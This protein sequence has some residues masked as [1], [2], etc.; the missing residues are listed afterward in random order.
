MTSDFTPA[1]QVIISLIPI[2]GI[3][4]GSAVAIMAIIFNHKQKKLMISKG[5]SPKT[6]KFDYMSFSLLFGL[7][8]CG[9]GLVLTVLFALLYR[10]SPALLG[11]L[12]PFASGAAF[13]VFYKIFPGFN[14]DKY[15]TD[16]K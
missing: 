2:I 12:V 5:L 3:A 11:G 1:A 15:K 13:L 4:M 14:K 16:E 6:E 10:I 9:I 8:L 7:L